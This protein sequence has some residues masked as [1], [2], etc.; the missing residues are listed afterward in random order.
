MNCALRDA[1]AQHHDKRLAAQG[2]A[3]RMWPPHKRYATPGKTPGTAGSC[4]GMV[5]TQTHPTRTQVRNG[6]RS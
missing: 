5:M 4:C 3:P 1:R 2:A 6:V